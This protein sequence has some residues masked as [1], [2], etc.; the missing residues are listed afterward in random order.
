MGHQFRTHADVIAGVGPTALSKALGR[1]SRTVT[2]WKLR[3]SIPSRYLL[4]VAQVAQA[5]GIDVTVES[6]AAMAAAP[7]LATETSD[8]ASD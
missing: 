2:A 7:V 5:A 1:P 3:N 6:L 8:G 4:P